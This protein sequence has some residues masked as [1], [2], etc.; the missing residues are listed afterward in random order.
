MYTIM[1]NPD[2]SLTT[3]IR[4][5]LYQREKN[6]NKIQ[7][8]LP[9][10]CE[11]VDIKSCTILL[12]YID[13]GNVAHADRLVMD[14]ELYKDTLIRCVMD[15]DTNLTRFAG[16]ISVNLS[17]LRLNPENGLHEE[18]LH[19]GKDIITINPLND[20]Y[21]FVGDDSLQ[22]IDKVILELEAK[23]KAQ[24]LIAS[25]YDTEKADNLVLD[26][27]KSTVYLSSHG[28]QIGEPIALNDLGD[29]IA[30]ET[31]S[32][33]IRVITEDEVPDVKQA[34]KYTLQ[35]DQENNTLS[36]LANGSVVSTISTKNIEQVIS[37]D[38]K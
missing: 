4:A 10:K 29:A 9:Q 3:T 16:D 18:V 35:L 25:T 8:L 27:D 20:L 14:T 15:V 2:K 12:K 11:E 23:Q 34:V 31:D 19:S 26:T 37:D 5:T 22:I 32:G 21:A 6:A 28:E 33:M 1:M 24:D 36:V 30:E 38:S 17:F 7:F 13:Q